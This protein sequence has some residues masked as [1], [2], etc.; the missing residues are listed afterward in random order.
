MHI[1]FSRCNFSPELQSLCISTFPVKSCT[2]VLLGIACLA[3]P[4]LS[5][6]SLHPILL[7]PLVI[8]LEI[9]DPTVPLVQV[10]TES[11]VRLLTSQKSVKSPDGWEGK[12]AVFWMLTAR[13]G[14]AGPCP[15]ADSSPAPAAG[16]SFYSLREGITY[17]NSTG[18]S[19]SHLEI[20]HGELTSIF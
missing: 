12:F 8:L 15:K 13:V 2:W 11:E 3:H 16:K 1:Y 6:W 18:R 4:N 19:D 14:G 20:G 5:S 7:L 9:G 17:R 10:V